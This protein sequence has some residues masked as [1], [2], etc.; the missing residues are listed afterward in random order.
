MTQVDK[1]AYKLQTYSH[2]PRF[3]SYF[4]Q[5]HEALALS[6]QSILEIG[7]GDG[8]FGSFIRQNS[9]IEYTSADY[10]QTLKPDV[11]ADVLDLPFRK[12]QFDLAC[13]FEVLEHIPFE[14]LD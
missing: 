14:R 6:P 2:E 5:L 1:K 8:V 7:V 10:D 4:H 11:V 3:V 13:A 9:D 12:G